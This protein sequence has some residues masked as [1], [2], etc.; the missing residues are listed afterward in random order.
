MTYFF[1][2][3]QGSHFWYLIPE[4]NCFLYFVVFPSCLQQTDNSCYFLVVR[5]GNSVM[6]TFKSFKLFELSISFDTVK[7]YLLV[8]MTSFLKYWCFPESCFLLEPCFF[9]DIF[10]MILCL[11]MSSGFIYVLMTPKMIF[12]TQISFGI[13]LYNFLLEIFMWMSWT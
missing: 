13:H 9:L 8:L 12:A 4:N 11:L 10:L 5:S 6:D 3:S 2:F 1:P 7:C